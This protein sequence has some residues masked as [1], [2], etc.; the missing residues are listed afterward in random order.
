MQSSKLKM[1]KLQFIWNV[2]L[3]CL[4]YPSL[5]HNGSS[6]AQ[7]DTQNTHAAVLCSNQKESAVAPDLPGKQMPCLQGIKLFK[8]SLERGHTVHGSNY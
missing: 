1:S 8:R 7:Q 2:L 6:G 4:P 5:T 3:D